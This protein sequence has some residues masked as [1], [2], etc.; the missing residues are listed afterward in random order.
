MSEILSS[1]TLFTLLV[2]Q[3]SWPSLIDW[4]TFATRELQMHHNTFHKSRGG[5][6]LPP[7]LTGILLGRRHAIVEVLTTAQDM[8]G[9]SQE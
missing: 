7:A 5:T 3:H 4:P 6:M 8:H 9:Q 2:M 1:V